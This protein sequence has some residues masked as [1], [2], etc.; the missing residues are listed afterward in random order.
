MDNVVIDDNAPPA[1]PEKAVAAGD[2][3][4]G[5]RVQQ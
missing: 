1:E 3:K 5:K 2:K 4:K